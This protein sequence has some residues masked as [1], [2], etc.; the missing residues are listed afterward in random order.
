M[1][2]TDYPQI[3]GSNLALYTET[4]YMAIC[5]KVPEFVDV[6]RK[7]TALA[8]QAYKDKMK[9][10][11]ERKKTLL[12]DIKRGYEEITDEC[13]KFME[14]STR[15][16][17]YYNGNGDLVKER[18]MEAQEMQKTVFEDMESTGTEG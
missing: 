14:R 15:T 7:L 13:F 11:K 8:N 10:K 5:G 1:N 12:T 9:P 6:D 3:F 4:N 17:G 2:K 16:T 18:P